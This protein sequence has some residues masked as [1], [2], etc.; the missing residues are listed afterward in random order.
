M[1]AIQ[2]AQ[3]L[4]VIG[5]MLVAQGARLVVIE[6]DDQALSVSWQ[7]SAADWHSQA[8]GKS[9]QL[10]A[11]LRSAVNGRGGSLPENDYKLEPLLRTLGQDLDRKGVRLGRIREIRGFQVRLDV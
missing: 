4:R 10:E 3:A 1:G 8:L 11:M 2:Y 6:E 9:D 7:D 5:R